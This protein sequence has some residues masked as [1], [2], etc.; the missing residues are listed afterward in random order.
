MDSTLTPEKLQEVLALVDKF[1]TLSSN[2]EVVHAQ[3]C[4]TENIFANMQRSQEQMK[5]VDKN[6]KDTI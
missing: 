2:M 3:A 6:R 5:Y 4:R 1:E